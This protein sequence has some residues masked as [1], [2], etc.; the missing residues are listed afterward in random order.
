MKHPPPLLGEND[1]T[2]M[3]SLK[4]PETPSVLSVFQWFMVMKKSRKITMYTFLS[5]FS[6]HPNVSNDW[7]YAIYV[8]YMSWLL[9][10]LNNYFKTILC[11]WKTSLKYFPFFNTQDGG[12]SDSIDKRVLLGKKTDRKKD[13][14]TV[15]RIGKKAMVYPIFLLERVSTKASNHI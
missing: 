15:K 2:K 13:R 14:R 3:I 10:K 1:Y 5:I 9:N 8:K 12:F 7:I 6:L 11:I 4:W